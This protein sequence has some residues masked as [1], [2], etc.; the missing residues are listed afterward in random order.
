VVLDS[1]RSTPPTLALTRVRFFGAFGGGDPGGGPGGGP[2][3]SAV[4]TGR[5]LITYT[6]IAN[7]GLGVAALGTSPLG[8]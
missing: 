8:S 3:G 4:G 1:V 7:G 6:G 5:Y 2:G